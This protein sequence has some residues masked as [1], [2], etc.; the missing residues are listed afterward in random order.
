M[1]ILIAGSAGHLDEALVHTLRRAGHT[2]VGLDILASSSTDELG[3][4]THPRN[5][6]HCIRGAD[7]VLHTATVHKPRQA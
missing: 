3:S 5:V 2:V 1:K 6:Q 7:A 4:I